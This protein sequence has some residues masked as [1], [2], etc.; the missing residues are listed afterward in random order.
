MKVLV[1]A[2]ACPVRKVIEKVAAC[3]EIPVIFF[4]DTSHIL[5][6]EYGSVVV[7]GKGSDAVDIA[8]INQAERGDIVVTQ[9]YGVAAMA[10]GKQA[11][12]IHQSGRIYTNENIGQKLFERHLSRMQRRSGKR[13]G[14][15]KRS[16]GGETS[17]FRDSFETLCRTVLADNGREA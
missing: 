10:L 5:D 15:I 11:Y 1:D 3:F 6:P 17:G 16:A 2:D 9:D 8:L 12:A 4:A 7:I 14:K 13:C